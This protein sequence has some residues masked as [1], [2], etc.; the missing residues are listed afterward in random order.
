MWCSGIPPV[1]GRQNKTAPAPR[2]ALS[3]AHSTAA[4]ITAAITVFA[5][6]TTEV[7]NLAYADGHAS[8]TRDTSGLLCGYILDNGG[9]V[10]HDYDLS[11]HDNYASDNN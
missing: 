9:M 6:A 4:L 5:A 8:D 1:R 11:G 2:P 3:T 7:G 10:L